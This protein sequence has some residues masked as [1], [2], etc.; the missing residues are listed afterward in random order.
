LA[1]LYRSKE[2]LE[3]SAVSDA[4]ARRY[5]D[6]NTARV[7]SEFKVMQ[8]LVR[9]QAAI[10]AAAAALAQGKDFAEVAAA[11]F[12]ELT[13]GQ[14]PWDLPQLTWE[15]VPS[16]WWPELDKLEVGKVSAVI[17]APGE[18]FWLIKLVERRANLATTFEVAKPRIQALL[19]S[20][21]YEERRAQLDQELR[22]KAKVERLQPPV[23]GP[24]GA[25]AAF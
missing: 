8:I 2:V 22:A 7:Q 15:Q 14:A 10:D 18:R 9:G 25:A 19:K 21:R 3:K 16:Q 5:F 6:A 11:Q 1:K 13:P 17:P 12:P 24:G 23:S 20:A 4:D